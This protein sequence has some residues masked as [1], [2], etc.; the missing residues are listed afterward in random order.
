MY[1]IT[2]KKQLPFFLPF[3]GKLDPDNR[4]IKL[5]NIIPWD[6]I[7]EKYAELFPTNCGMSAKPLRVALVL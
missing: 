6:D 1:Q 5:S 3:G 7:E 2:D 4:W